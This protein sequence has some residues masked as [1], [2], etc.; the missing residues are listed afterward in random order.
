M[1]DIVLCGFESQLQAT[2]IQVCDL[3]N[4]FVCFS[5]YGTVV[6]MLYRRPIACMPG[7]MYHKP[8]AALCTVLLQLSFV[9]FTDDSGR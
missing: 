6:C 4:D 3:N 9:S 2:A 1:L 5:W 7:A 8:V